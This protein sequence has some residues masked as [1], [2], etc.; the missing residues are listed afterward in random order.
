MALGVRGS[1]PLWLLADLQGN[2]FDD[3]YYMFVLE[4]T[5]PYSPLPVY[6]DPDLNIVWDN[7]IQFLSNGTLPIDIYFVDGVVYR[8]EFRKNNGIDPPS[9]NDPLIYEVNNYIPGDGGANPIDTVALPTG[10]QITNPQFALVNFSSSFTLSSATNPEPIEIAPG[11]FLELGGT[12]SVTATQVALSSTNENPSNAPY[13]LRLQLTGWNTEEVFL[14]QRFQQN[15]MLWANQFVSSTITCRMQSS[16]QS[17]SANLVDSMNT[18]LTQVLSPQQVN[19]AWNE[20]T[21]YGELG[22]TT[23]TDTPPDAYIDYKLALPS[24]VDI[25]ITSIQLIVQDLPIEPDFEQDSIERQKDH[26]FHYYQPAL[27]F[28]PVPSLLTGWDFPLN[29]SQFSV[30]GN[31]TTTA[32]YIW[33]QTIGYSRTSSIGFNR[34]SVTSGL[35]LTTSGSVPDSFLLCQ[36]LSGNQVRKLLGTSLSVNLNSWITSGSVT[37]TI[38]LFRGSSSA[39]IPALPNLIG[40]LSADGTFTL[41]STPGQGQNW[42]EINR[43]VFGAPFG[44]LSIVNAGTPSQINTNQNDYGFSGWEITDDSQ[45][46]NTNKFCMIITFSY[47]TQPTLIVVQSVSLVPGDIPTRPAPQSPDEVLRECQY[48]WRGSFLPGTVPAQNAGLNTGEVYG[49]QIAGSG[50]VNRI[51]VRFSSPMRATPVSPPVFYNP[52]ASNAQIRNISN[53]S[54]YSATGLT[55]NTLTA[56]GFVVEGTS[57]GSSNNLIGVHYTADARLG[58]I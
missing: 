33:D 1:N 4:N 10:N 54:D 36:Y 12:G 53:S 49:M 46:N 22:D 57:T 35:S 51:P 34:N 17:I 29:P 8:L 48:Y 14:R 20:F 39:V 21:G 16:V 18:P 23:N 58:I 7:P 3:T 38:Y 2:L 52:S 15:G 26:T 28:K 9:Q 37:Y 42:T 44:N 25:Y 45:I 50:V 11:W 13:A 40:S 6:H 27:N 19:S 32:A 31:I 24:N 43:G 56:N 41:N 55:A 5:I 30:S 47:E